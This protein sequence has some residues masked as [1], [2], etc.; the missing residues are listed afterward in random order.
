[1]LTKI[2]LQS[3]KSYDK[4]APDESTAYIEWEKRSIY[5]NVSDI[6]KETIRH[7]LTH[8]YIKASFTEQIPDL[9]LEQLEE[10]FC[11]VVSHFGT[12][13]IKQ[14]DSIH[15][16]MLSLIKEDKFGNSKDKERKSTKSVYGEIEQEREEAD[17]RSE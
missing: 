1:M 12:T 8:A 4:G 13:I 5:F 17:F 2:Y 11:E 3:V 10:I 15:K 7:E 14:A 9:T 6:S 16:E